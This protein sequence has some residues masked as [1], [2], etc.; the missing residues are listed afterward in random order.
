MAE[1]PEKLGYAYRWLDPTFRSN[2]ASYFA[3][4]NP[5][6]A[7]YGSTAW[8]ALVDPYADDGVAFYIATSSIIGSRVSGF[9]GSFVF[10]DATR[11][12]NI[13][14]GATLSATVILD[15]NGSVAAFRS[16]AI[17]VPSW[18]GSDWTRDAAC[19]AWGNDIGS[20]STGT[21]G[22]L[23]MQAGI[24]MNDFG[25]TWEPWPDTT[26]YSDGPLHRDTWNRAICGLPH[27]YFSGNAGTIANYSFAK[28]TSLYLNSTDMPYN[29]NATLSGTS[30]SGTRLTL[31]FQGKSATTYAAFDFMSV[32]GSFHGRG[33]EEILIEMSQVYGPAC[34]DPEDP[35][36]SWG[37]DTIVANDQIIATVVLDFVD[38]G[39]HNSQR[40]P[41]QYI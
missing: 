22:T 1:E 24:T 33:Y 5:Y 3:G 32:Y 14:S 27:F 36:A 8:I 26:D 15:G 34:Y 25:S 41:V 18:N 4:G 9:Y 29:L 31:Y 6:V 19:I 35:G 10:S 13:D 16:W 30:V 20:C 40:I 21:F 7:P 11:V 38:T 23:T 17:M 2:L 12:S 28:W 37:Y 39:T